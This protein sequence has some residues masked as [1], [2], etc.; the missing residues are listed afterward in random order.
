MDLVS[1]YLQLTHSA[2]QYSLNRMRNIFGSVQ[3]NKPY[4]NL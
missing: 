2:I 1:R 4:R 3:S